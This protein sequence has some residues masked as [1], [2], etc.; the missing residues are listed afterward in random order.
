[1]PFANFNAFVPAFVNS[2]FT[3]ISNFAVRFSFKN[4]YQ[5]SAGNMPLYSIEKVAGEGFLALWEV[6]ESEKELVE[7]C[8]VPDEELEISIVE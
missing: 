3:L 4:V 5:A 7:I 8:S 6:T 2:L 1:M